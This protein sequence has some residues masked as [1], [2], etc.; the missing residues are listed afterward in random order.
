MKPIIYI[1][2]K[3][4]ESLDGNPKIID[5]Y[6]SA[7]R[8]LF[9]V[10]NPQ[11]KNGSAGS[12]QEAIEAR[13]EFIKSLVIE[14]IW[15]YYPERNAI[16]KTVPEDIYFE[17]RTSRNRNI[18]TLDEQE[19]YRNT[20]VGIAGLSVGSAVVAALTMSGGP[21]RM[22]IADFDELELTNLN[23][24]RATA[25]DLGQNKTYIAAR[26]V[27]EL[28][29]FAEL[30]L[31]DKGLT[32]ENISDFVLGLNVFVDE[33]DSIGL[34][35]LSRLVAR[36]ARIPVLMATD[37]GDSV[38]L[39]VERF[40]LEPERALFH[41]LLAEEEIRQ[42][43][44]A[45]M[46]IDEMRGMSEEQ[47]EQY[48]D[49]IAKEHRS[50]EQSRSQFS[51]SP[52]PKDYKT[53]LTLATKIVSAEYLTERMQDSI[54]SIGK[55]IPAVPQLGTTASIAGAAIAYAV[56][57]IANGYDLPSGRYALGCEEKLIPNYMS[58]EAKHKREEKTKDFLLSFPT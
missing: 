3:D 9:G 17:L 39:D 18:I 53:W 34:K 35:I 51:S 26:G 15:I 7:L 21:K 43:I 28:D 1:N 58:E 38:I 6:T 20:I 10:R 31:F 40:D 52:D 46:K 33:M 56:R 47:T 57:R 4:I 32:A 44:P 12:P 19:K 42:F 23:R 37:N 25:L 36:E 55:V 2:E 45:E 5:G 22:K 30:T 54:A 29:P 48:E 41:G 11:W 24:L 49:S 50:S 8:E 16:L 14:P 27:W 13:E